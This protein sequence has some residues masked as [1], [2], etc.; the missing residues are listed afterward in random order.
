MARK[1]QKSNIK[2]E[3][4]TKI[5]PRNTISNIIKEITKNKDVQVSAKAIQILHETLEIY[6]HEIFTS[7]NDI[8]QLRG[9]TQVS[10]ADF[11]LA[12]ELINRIKVKT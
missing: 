1:K 7:A 4:T 6:M 8:A 2:N 5:F 11:K 3:E 10:L 12:T 9:S